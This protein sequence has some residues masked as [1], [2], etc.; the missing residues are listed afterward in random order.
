M[1]GTIRRRVVAHGL[2]QGVSFRETTRETAE[3]AGVAGWVRNRPDGVVEAVFEG[4]AS[5]V[6]ELV[7]HCRVGP[8][9]A[10]VDRIDVVD[11]SPAGL[12]GF[13]IRATP[14]E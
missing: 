9:G 10:R 2:V 8:P 12:R 6:D 3:A 11:E 5:A 13:T 4:A 1:S 7:A 14:R